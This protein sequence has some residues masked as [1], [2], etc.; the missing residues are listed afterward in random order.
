MAKGCGPLSRMR[1]AVPQLL[2]S[3]TVGIRT[4]ECAY[5]ADLPALVVNFVEDAIGAASCAIAN[6]QGTPELLAT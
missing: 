1:V 6:I 5:H 2:S 4:A 3:A